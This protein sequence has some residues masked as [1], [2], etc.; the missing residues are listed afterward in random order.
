MLG[1]RL[2]VLFSLCLVLVSGVSFG[3][4]VADLTK[5]GDFFFGLAT[6]PA[7]V[8]DQLDDTWLRFAEAGEVKAYH[9][10]VRPGDRLEFWTNPEVEIQLAAD[11]GVKVF[12]LG[13]DWGRLVMD[14]SDCTEQFCRLDEA[15]LTRYIE[16]IQLVKDRGMEPMV[17]LFHH[18][19]P[20]WAKEMGGWLAPELRDQFIWFS[21]RVIQE[22]A[23][24]VKLWITFNEPT[25]YS[26]L[27]YSASMWPDRRDTDRHP[28]SII[29]PKGSFCVASKLMASAHKSIYEYAHGY[30]SF[31]EL[32]K[33][34]IGIAHN[35]T[36]HLSNRVFEKVTSTYMSY[37]MNYYFPDMIVGHLDYLGINYY[38]VEYVRGLGVEMRPD[39]EYSESGRA[40]EPRVLYDLLKVFHRRYN[41]DGVGRE[42]PFETL[43]FIVTENGISD[44]S[45]RLRPAYLIEHLRAV[46]AA[47]KEGVPVKGYI[48]WTVSDNWEWADGYCPK[49]GMV[50]VIRTESELIRVKRP[51][52]DL[53]TDIVK[54][55]KIYKHQAERAWMLVERGVGIPRPFCRDDDGE[56]PLD[57]PGRRKIVDYD[58]RF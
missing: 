34:Q 28:L 23:P 16:I 58:W 55:G 40:V 48:F 12:R 49:F 9:N 54:E 1:R 4:V 35:V 33:P 46:E 30:Y 13:V 7:H 53:F 36:K 21:K 47:K 37:L 38:G 18:S 10:Q 19:A 57:E 17:T 3:S 26:L 20:L 6:A 25:I 56:T 44:G 52:Y 29:C 43:P 39:R 51:S 8:E 15:A 22:L 11:T 14:P 5:Q 42:K 50:A 41:E 24:H 2:F 45:D 32:E 31:K 27:N